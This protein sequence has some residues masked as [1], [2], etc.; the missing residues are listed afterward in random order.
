VTASVSPSCVVQGGTVTV[1]V[2]TRSKAAVAFGAR[3]ADGGYGA[4]P[5]YGKGYGGSG[6]GFADEGGTY[7]A[8]WAVAANAPPGQAVVD[9]LVGSNGKAG[10][11]RPAFTV[12]AVT[13]SC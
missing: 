1:T 13:S 6:H 8:S 10:S 2:H 7:T 4:A 3:Y 11:T 9:V 5:P 12:R